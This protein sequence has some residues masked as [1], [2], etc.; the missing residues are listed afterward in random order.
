MKALLLC[1]QEYGEVNGEP[2]MVLNREVTKEVRDR[3]GDGRHL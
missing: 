3:H 2:M 1:A